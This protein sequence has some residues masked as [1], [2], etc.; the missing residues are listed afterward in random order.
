[1][2]AVS[3]AGSRRDP[4]ADQGLRPEPD[5]QR[6]GGHYEPECQRG[7]QK[8]PLGLSQRHGC[9]NYIVSTKAY[10][11]SDELRFAKSEVWERQ[12]TVTSRW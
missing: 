3:D 4:C 6:S 1:V 7:L 2:D 8:G 11:A 10:L 9:G 5:D 12:S